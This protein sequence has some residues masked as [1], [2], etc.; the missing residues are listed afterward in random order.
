ME[1]AVEEEGDKLQP[2][3]QREGEEMVQAPRREESGVSVVGAA[4]CNML[5]A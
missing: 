3:L 1:F 5:T 4:P 2:E